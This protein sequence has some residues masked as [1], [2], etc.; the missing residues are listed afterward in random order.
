MWNAGIAALAGAGYGLAFV[1]INSD[2]FFTQGA[3]VGAL[4]AAVACAD[5]L[6]VAR[7]TEAVRT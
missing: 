2:S 7:P 6:F 4:V 5:V 3:I 1:A